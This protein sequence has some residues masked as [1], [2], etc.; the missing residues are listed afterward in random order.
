MEPK[1]PICG[2]T[3]FDNREVADDKFYICSYVIYCKKCGY[4]VGCAW[5]MR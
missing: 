4:P 1:C 2:G 3:E 5:G